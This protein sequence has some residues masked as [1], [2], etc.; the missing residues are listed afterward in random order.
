MIRMEKHEV[1]IVGA[2]P[3]G[4]KAAELL[5]KAEKDVLVIEKD[6]EERIGDKPCA[7]GL[8]PHAMKYF[9]EDLYENVV[10]SITLVVGGRELNV[11]LG[12]PAIALVSRLDMGQYQLKLAKEAGAQIMANTSVKGLDKEKNEVILNN[13]ER[14]GYEKL[15]AADG[16]TSIIRRALGFNTKQILQCI[17]YPV[18]GDFE[19]LE[20]DFDL[21]NYGLTYI[22]I[23][24]HR[25]YA[26]IG[27]G[28]FP[29]MVPAQEMNQRFNRWAEKKG[30]DLSKAK[31]RA[32]PIYV[33][34]HGFK[35]NNIF[36]TGD[37][38]SFACP[39]DGEGIYQAIKSGE[40]AAKAIIDPKWNYNPELK[41]LLKYHRFGGWL[42]PW[43]LMFPKLSRNIVENLGG[44]LMPAISTVVPVVGSIKF[45]QRAAF[46]IVGK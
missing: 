4:L 22:W 32:H 30:I 27:T 46:G 19:R 8:P 28:M 38:A 31:R 39:I 24:P 34:Y 7:G 18:K 35:H 10:S 17:E 45:L 42:F 13:E 33:G 6:R 1:V 44:M 26:S 14:I 2:G 3:A 29:S 20:V 11:D 12:E 21:K 15:M 5:G 40:I 43:M 41:D 36:L 25:G 37:A 16:S 23:F 9:P